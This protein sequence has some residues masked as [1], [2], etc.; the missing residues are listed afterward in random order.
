VIRDAVAELA[1]DPAI[2]L[3]DDPTVCSDATV[4]WAETAIRTLHRPATDEEAAALLPLLSRA[5][6]NSCYGLLFQLVHFVESAPN[7][8]P[9]ELLDSISGPWLDVL[10]TGLKNAGRSV[11]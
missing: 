3:S 4:A 7:W 2:I 5:Q 8:P 9:A 11:A 10:R 6:E 1:R